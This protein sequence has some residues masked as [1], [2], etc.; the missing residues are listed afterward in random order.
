MNISLS[1]QTRPRR[2]IRFRQ[3]PAFSLVEVLFAVTFLL[4]VGLGMS[5]LNSAAA[6]LITSAETKLSA[7]ALNEQA[8]SYL[9]VQRKAQG[10]S[11]SIGPCEFD[12]TCYIYCDPEALTLNCTLQTTSR[13]IQLGRSR[14]QYVTEFKA[15]ALT[16]GN[17]TSYLLLAKTSWGSGV[18]RSVTSGQVVDPR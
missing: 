17:T 11:F 6:R 7:Y 15:R 1:P 9:S 3:A 10:E 16:A 5:A 4:M 18:N 2:L 13:A 12:Q 8:L 14:L